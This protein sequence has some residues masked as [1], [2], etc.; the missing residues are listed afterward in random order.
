[1][2][3]P[4]PIKTEGPAALLANAEAYAESKTHKST[5]MA[6]GLAMM[7]GLFIGLAF[8]FYLTVTTGSQRRLGND[9]VDGRACL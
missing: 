9:P 8:V 5:R 1:M 4:T 3:S 2:V 6:V 7:A